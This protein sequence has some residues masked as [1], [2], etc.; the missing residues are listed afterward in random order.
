MLYLYIFQIQFQHEIILSEWRSTIAQTNHL[1]K[2]KG[3]VQLTCITIFNFRIV[4]SKKWPL[5][6]WTIK[7][8]TSIQLAYEVLRCSILRIAI[9][10]HL[11]LALK[12]RFNQF[13]WTQ[14]SANSNQSEAYFSKESNLFYCFF[15]FF[16]RTHLWKNL[17]FHSSWWVLFCYDALVSEPGKIGFGL[18]GSADPFLTITQETGKARSSMHRTH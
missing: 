16:C 12:S 7:K 10:F 4:W 18:G 17:S 8:F 15:A 6:T 3:S 5:L 2:T 9:E 1:V 14:I 13:V 11:K